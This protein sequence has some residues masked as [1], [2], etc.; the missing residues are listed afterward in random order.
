MG[1]IFVVVSLIGLAIA[2]LPHNPVIGTAGVLIY[3]K[4]IWEILTRV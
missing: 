4:L 1:F 3:V 2:W